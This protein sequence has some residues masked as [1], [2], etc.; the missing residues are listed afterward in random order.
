MP[1]PFT[2]H[3]RA[4]LTHTGGVC[5]IEAGLIGQLAD[6]ECKHGRLPGD[7]TPKCGCWPT[8]LAPIIALPDH[9][10]PVIHSVREA[11]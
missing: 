11:A 6:N 5:P 10:Q 7:R 3:Y 2:A 8:E 9:R 4:A 1:N